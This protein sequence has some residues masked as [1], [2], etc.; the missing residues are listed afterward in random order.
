MKTTEI[1]AYIIVNILERDNKLPK[2]TAD[3]YRGVAV[4]PGI[5]SL[6]DE[7]FKSLT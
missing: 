3:K 2:K 1:I 5:S 7:S 4:P 6:L